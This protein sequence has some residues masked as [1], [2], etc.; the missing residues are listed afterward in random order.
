[1]QNISGTNAATW[2]QK[3][4]ADSPSLKEGKSA[5]ALTYSTFAAAFF[6]P[7]HRKCK[8]TLKNLICSRTIGGYVKDRMWAEEAEL[9]KQ[10]IKKN[11][12]ETEVRSLT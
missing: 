6:A 3:L 9:V 2:W 7:K 5:R 8:C 1:L 4:A 12:P 10:M 11:S